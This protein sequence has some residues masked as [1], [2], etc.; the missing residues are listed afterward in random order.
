MRSQKRADKKKEIEQ[1]SRGL[2]SLT[3]GVRWQQRDHLL[4]TVQP[5]ELTEK[6]RQTGNEKY[7]RG[8]VTLTQ[9]VRWI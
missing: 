2:V 9:G 4:T 6:D 7:S 3:Q 1:Y 5:D 8:I